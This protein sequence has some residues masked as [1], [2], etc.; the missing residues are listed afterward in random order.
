M[1][2]HWPAS[3][4]R[5]RPLDFLK[6]LNFEGPQKRSDAAAAIG[7]AEQ[8]VNQPP[9]WDKVGQNPTVESSA[10]NG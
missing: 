1:R 6:T 3:P 9:P 10:I 4:D 2:R 7:S 5:R 8:V